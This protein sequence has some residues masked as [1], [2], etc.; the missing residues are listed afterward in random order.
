LAKVWLAIPPELPNAVQRSLNRLPKNQGTI[1]AV[2]TGVFHGSRS[3]FGDGGYQYQ[4][5][6]EHLEQVEVVSRSGVVPEALRD[7]ERTKVC[8]GRLKA[9]IQDGTIAPEPKK[10]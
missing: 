3:A 4:L 6:L 10:P 2:L 7:S 9:P 8:Q 5:D 1:N